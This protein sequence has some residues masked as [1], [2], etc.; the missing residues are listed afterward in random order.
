MRGRDPQGARWMAWTCA[1]LWAACVFIHGCSQVTDFDRFHAIDAGPDADADDATMDV[2]PPP[3]DATMDDA[4]PA[5]AAP[6]ALLDAAPTDATPDALLDAAPAD[7]TPDAL[8]DA[9]PTDATPDALLDAAP[10]DAAPD[11][12]LG[13]AE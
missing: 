5:D 7:A 3:L 2:P 8:L 1:W 11:A 12:L 10:T 13:E 4:A 6:D 9:A